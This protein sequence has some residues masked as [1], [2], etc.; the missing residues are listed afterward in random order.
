VSGDATFA[1][2]GGAGASIIRSTGSLAQAGS[3]SLSAGNRTLT[4]SNGSAGVDLQVRAAITGA[5]RLVKSGAGTMQLS[6]MNSYS[7]GTTVSA[8]TLQLNADN[9][10]GAVPGSFQ[11]SNIVLD[12]GTLRT[13]ARIDSTS[14]TNA[15]TNYTSFPALALNGAGPDALAASANVLAGI[16]TIAVTA[17][18]SRYGHRTPPSPPPPHTPP[19]F[20]YILSGR[21]PQASP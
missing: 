12:G 17:G 15:G 4:V 9:Q 21:G 8:G 10:L 1:Q 20:R 3:V 11:S 16:R 7:G 2:T 14:L 5:G 6:G 19:P 18:G 13:G